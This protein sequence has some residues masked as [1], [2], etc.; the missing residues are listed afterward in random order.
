MVHFIIRDGCGSFYI[1]DGCG[2]FYNKGWMWFI[3]L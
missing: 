1:R 3:L 2:S